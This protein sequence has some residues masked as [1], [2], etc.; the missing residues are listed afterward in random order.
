MPRITA[1]VFAVALCTMT[2]NAL[3][4]GRPPQT[5]GVFVQ[6]GDDQTVLVSSTFGLMISRDGGSSFQWV[7]ED[8][9]GYGGVFDP[10]FA[11]AS[12]GT[13]FA[14]TN[15]ELRISRDDGCTWEPAT[16]ELGDHWIDDIEIGPAGEIWAIT[17]TTGKAND[18]YRSNDNGTSF[19]DRNMRND[20]AFWKSIRVA[21]SDGQRI[22]LTG[23]EV[24]EDST[25]GGMT[26]PAP[27]LFRS[28]DGGDSWTPLD[29]EGIELANLP[30]FKLLAVDPDDPT[31]VFG[32]SVNAN[33][34]QGD[35]LYRSGDAGD[36]WNEVL[37]TETS[38]QA[39]VIRK[40]G[41]VIVGTT[42]NGASDNR[43]FV[44]SDGNAPFDKAA[45][46]LQMA[47]IAELSNG[48]L[49]A[50]GANWEPDFLAL[51]RSS[52]GNEWTKLVRFSEIQS[53]YQCPAETVQAKVCEAVQWPALCLQFGCERPMIQADAGPSPIDR[54]TGGCCDAGANPASTVLLA[55]FT[56]LF[57]ALLFRRRRATRHDAQS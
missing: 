16:G 38:I 23:Y 15:R 12:D 34:L 36:S 41:Q 27:L 10:D 7:C 44:S 49:L 6:S 28:P 39:F 35:I 32:R 52:D 45:S 1:Y 18:V 21:P 46:Q 31:V 54:D 30:L 5:V 8:A 11:I 51:G 9:I 50:C 48:D 53:A 37:R 2:S 56:G 19:I 20:T 43:V 24:V 26:R 33:G 42:N 29:F 17:A 13:I 22:Y 14:G 3:G 4:N 55:L 47:C 57:L 40:N 25:D